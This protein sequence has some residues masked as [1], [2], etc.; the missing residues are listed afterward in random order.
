LL[1]TW[2]VAVAQS[3]EGRQEEKCNEFKGSMVGK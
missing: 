2:V 1:V 3:A